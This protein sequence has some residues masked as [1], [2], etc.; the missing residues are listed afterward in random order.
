MSLRAA[1]K[2]HPAPEKGQ[3]TSTKGHAAMCAS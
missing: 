3:E 1:L 2:A